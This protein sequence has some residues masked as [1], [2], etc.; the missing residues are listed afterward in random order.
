MLV[1]ATI[2]GSGLHYVWTWG[3][4]A[5]RTRRGAAAAGQR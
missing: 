4:R 1:T 3:R 2:V 5:L